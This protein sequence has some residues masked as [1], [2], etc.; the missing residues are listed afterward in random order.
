MDRAA[1]WV[2]GSV[3]SGKDLKVALPLPPQLVISKKKADNKA[4]GAIN[5]VKRL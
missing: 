2:A 4:T 5:R 3:G 1:I